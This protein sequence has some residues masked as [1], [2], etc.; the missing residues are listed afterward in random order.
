VVYQKQNQNLT[1]LLMRKKENQERGDTTVLKIAGLF[2]LVVLAMS[3]PV[4]A[5]D[6]VVLISQ[7]T[8]TA[9]GGFPFKIT[10]PGSYKLTTN[11]VV[12]ADK[13]GIIVAAQDVT[14]DLNG[15]GITGA[16]LCD[17][18]GITCAPLPARETIGI[19]A[20]IGVVNGQAN[21]I[22]GVN[23][24]NGHVRGFTIGISTFGGIVEEITAQ[25]NLRVG[26]QGFNT[27]VRRNDV[28]RNHGSGIECNQCI[29]RDN[30]A[31]FN[32]GN[33]FTLVFGGVFAGNTAVT[34]SGTGLGVDITNDVTS[35][36]N[37]SCNRFRC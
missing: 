29:V 21:N 19:E 25:G 4:F 15:F 16:V 17:V 13:G 8:V 6:G 7:S 32:Q 30:M 35:D 37:N 22:F 24:K 11:L 18:Q 20:V 2:L 23:I 5:V 27:V 26:V 9:A 10:Q 34:Q 1:G 14:L 36:N 12:P 28:S 3:L 31:A 33:Q